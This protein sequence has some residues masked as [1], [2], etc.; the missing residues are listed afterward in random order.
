MTGGIERVP[1]AAIS[2]DRAQRA[3]PAAGARAA[4]R[5]FLRFFPRGFRDETYIAWERDYKMK[6]HRDWSRALDEKSLRAMNRRGAH[7]EVAA[8]AV[9][10]ESRTNLLF[11]F[12]KIALRDAVRTTTGARQFAT[13][14]EDFLYGPGKLQS[15]FENWVEAIGELPRFQTRVLT[16]PVVTVFGFIA[17]PRTHI[18]LKPTVTRTAAELYGADFEYRSQPCWATYESL[19]RFAAR[20]RRDLSDLRPRDWIDI[21]SFIWVQGS[22]EYD[23]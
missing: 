18:Y 12:E 14:L 2:L 17:Q 10:I 22:S 19:M 16:W 9:R 21:Q 7:R 23:E 15:R 6:A 11:S 8:L 13:A 3:A 4:R 5:K 20:V 1:T